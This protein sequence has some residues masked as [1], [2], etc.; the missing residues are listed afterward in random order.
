MLCNAKTSK[1][2]YCSNKALKG[3]KTCGIQAHKKQFKKKKGG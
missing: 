2:A 3:S 1:G